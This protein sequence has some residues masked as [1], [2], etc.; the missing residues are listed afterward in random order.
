MVVLTAG[1]A[2][3]VA[4]EWGEQRRWLQ[5]DGG[6]VGGGDGGGR[7]SF[8]ALMPLVQSVFFN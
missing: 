4:M 8:K 1:V 5:G 3:A 7:G 2:V 6:C